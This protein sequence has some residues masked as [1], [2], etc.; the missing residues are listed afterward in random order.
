[1][2][3]TI[4]NISGLHCVSCCQNI[5]GGLEDQDG[6][7]SSNTNYAKSKTTIEFEEDKITEKQ[8]EKIITDLGYNIV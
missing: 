1:M 5:D 4:Y 2:K 7:I 6:I 8:I 3:R